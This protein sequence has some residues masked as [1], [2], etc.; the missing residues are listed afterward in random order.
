MPRQLYNLHETRFILGFIC[1]NVL[2]NQK[3][4]PLFTDG[5][6]TEVLCGW[7][8]I[9]LLLFVFTGKLLQFFISSTDLEFPLRANICLANISYWKKNWGKKYCSQRRL[10]LHI[11]KPNSF[12]NPHFLFFGCH[13]DGFHQAFYPACTINCTHNCT[14]KT[15]Q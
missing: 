12:W 2:I 14:H 6:R 3:S 7:Q 13:E 5:M 1:A 4:I 9:I 15:W 8:L 10:T 11:C